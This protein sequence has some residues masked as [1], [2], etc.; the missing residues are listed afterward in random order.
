MRDH[1]LCDEPGAVVNDL[2]TSPVG[3]E[4]RPRGIADRG[5]GDGRLHERAL[6]ADVKHGVERQRAR[7]VETFV[8]RGGRGVPPQ[9][10]HQA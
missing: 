3:G 2:D 10:Q 7:G 5:V 8:E 4:Q 6:C 1:A 9:R